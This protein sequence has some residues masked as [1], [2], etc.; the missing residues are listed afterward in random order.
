MLGNKDKELRR[1]MGS[2]VFTTSSDGQLHHNFGIVI[3]LE[4]AKR[5]VA[6]L[7]LGL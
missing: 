5:L 3:Q 1:L 2:G 4:D 6:M 7:Y